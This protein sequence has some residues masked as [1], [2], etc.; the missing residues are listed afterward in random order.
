MVGGCYELL[1]KSQLNGLTTASL[2]KREIIWQET[3]GP[4]Q[5]VIKYNSLCVERRG[6]SPPTASLT[7]Q[8]TVWKSVKFSTGTKGSSCNVFSPFILHSQSL[9]LSVPFRHLVIINFEVMG[10]RTVSLIF[11]SQFSNPDYSYFFIIKIV[12][13]LPIS[14]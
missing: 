14:F 8:P 13:E 2:S 11:T 1:T 12:F 7:S 9:E 6:H 10:G 5:H 3:R 4:L